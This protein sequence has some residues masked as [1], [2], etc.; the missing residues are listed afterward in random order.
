MAMAMTTVPGAP[1]DGEATVEVPISA[2]FG[3]ELW[4]VSLVTNGYSCVRAIYRPS[5]R[6]RRGKVAEPYWSAGASFQDPA[7]VVAF[8][9]RERTALAK[10]AVDLLVALGE[11]PSASSG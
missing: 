8:F 9:V 7:G 5:A 11:P 2:E 3:R 10:A 6:V 4:S 1:F